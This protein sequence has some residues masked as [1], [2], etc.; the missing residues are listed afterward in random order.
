MET[1]YRSHAVEHRPQHARSHRYE[2]HWSRAY[3]STPLTHPPLDPI[4]IIGVAVF[5]GNWR[6]SAPANLTISG[7]TGSA[8]ACTT[9]VTTTPTST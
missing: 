4:I 6:Q 5:G 2:T 1:D 9:R 7:P 8:G 3:V